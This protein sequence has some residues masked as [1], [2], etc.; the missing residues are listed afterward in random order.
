MLLAAQNWDISS[1]F[2]L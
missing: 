1:C 2:C